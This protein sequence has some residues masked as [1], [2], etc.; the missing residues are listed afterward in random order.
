MTILFENEISDNMQCDREKAAME[1]RRE[2]QE[3]DG[4]NRVRKSDTHEPC[5]KDGKQPQ[6]DQTEEDHEGL[7]TGPQR[8]GKDP[9]SKRQTG[10]VLIAN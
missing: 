2:H 9:Q 3:R 8:G 1:K 4:L 7:S 6:A 5:T 10:L